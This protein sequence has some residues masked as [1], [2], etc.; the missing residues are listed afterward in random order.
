[1]LPKIAFTAIYNNY[2]YCLFVS[3]LYEQFKKQLLIENK[4]YDCL[5][6]IYSIVPVIYCYL[7]VIYCH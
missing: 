5:N 6:L 1:M 4:E 7:F 2:N 3:E